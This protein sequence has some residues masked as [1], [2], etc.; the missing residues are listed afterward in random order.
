M[1]GC[2][3]EFGLLAG[4]LREE[5]LPRRTCHT[6][7]VLHLLMNLYGVQRFAGAVVIRF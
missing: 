3:V 1:S 6:E 5:E 7:S 2:G 4:G